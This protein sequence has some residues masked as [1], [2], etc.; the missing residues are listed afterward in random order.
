MRMVFFLYA[1]I[2][3]LSP[4]KTLV[5]SSNQINAACESFA[6]GEIMLI[7]L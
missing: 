4:A 7:K 2:G 1:L 6:A 5:A 3:F